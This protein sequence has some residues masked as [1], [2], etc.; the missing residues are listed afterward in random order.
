[1]YLI[2][3]SELPARRLPGRPRHGWARLSTIQ[4]RFDECEERLSRASDI[5]RERSNQQESPRQTDWAPSRRA[6][7]VLAL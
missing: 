4:F 1:M 2:C 3:Y 7:E 6:L 5:L